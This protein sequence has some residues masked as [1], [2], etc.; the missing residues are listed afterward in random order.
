M[1]YGTI[2]GQRQLVAELGSCSLGMAQDW[3][4]A[5]EGCEVSLQLEPDA[6]ILKV[7]VPY[8]G[9]PELQQRS[10]VL[11]EALSTDQD[12]VTALAAAPWRS[13]PSAHTT[14]HGFLGDDWP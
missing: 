9:M 12:L 1:E 2:D 14:K 13:T 3:E 10:V 7:R 4:Q 8:Q 5:V 11:L 6:S